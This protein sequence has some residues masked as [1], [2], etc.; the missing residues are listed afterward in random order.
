MEINIDKLTVT[1]LTYRNTQTLT[2]MVIFHQLRVD[3][4]FSAVKLNLKVNE[5]YIT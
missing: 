1:R 2:H 5:T 4:M 3:I